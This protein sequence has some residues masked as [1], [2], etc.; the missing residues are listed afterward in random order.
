MNDILPGCVLTALQ[1][2]YKNGVENAEAFYTQHSAD[3]DSVTGALGQALAK[4]D[5]IHCQQG[6][7]NYQIYVSYQKL[8]GRGSHAPEKSSGADGVFE[9]KILDQHGK[10]IGVKGLP[11][12]SKKNWSGIDSTLLNQAIKMENLAPG[13]IVIDYS[14]I[15]YSACTSKEV[16]EAQG[17]RKSVHSGGSLK[18]LAEILSRDFLDCNVGHRGLYYDRNRE[19]FHFGYW[20]Q[21]YRKELHMI[22]TEV[23]RLE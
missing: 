6:T 19:K 1:E 23:K 18:S 2:H 3:E 9:L 12:Q 10:K 8:R 20:R 5:P 15:G 13:G 21:P 7:D 16:I 22:T 17:N 11:F 14:E 4:R